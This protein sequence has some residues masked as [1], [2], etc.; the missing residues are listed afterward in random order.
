MIGINQ[1]NALPIINGYVSVPDI[2]S[3]DRLTVAEALAT[4]DGSYISDYKI[5]GQRF[6]MLPDFERFTGY[7]T[8]WYNQL[9]SAAT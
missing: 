4:I 9:R 6:L 2:N 5:N 7:P 8:D 1:R 3:T